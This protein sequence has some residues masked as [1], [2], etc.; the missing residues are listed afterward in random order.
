M[1]AAGTPGVQGVA[2]KFLL[3]QDEE[4]RWFPDTALPDARA[5]R[6]WIVKLPRGRHGTDFRILRHEAIYLQAAAASGLRTIATPMLRENMLFLPRFDRLVD[7]N[8]VTRVH[9]RSEEHTSELQSLMR[10]SYAVFCLKKKIY[11]LLHNN[12]QQTLD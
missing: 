11:K 8:G 1:L 6:H 3:T 9:Q 10:I 4:G 2:P 7:G 5:R 12:T